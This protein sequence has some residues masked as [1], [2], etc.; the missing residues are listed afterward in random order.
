MLHPG[1]TG[2]GQAGFARS[3]SALRSPLITV[4]TSPRRLSRRTILASRASQDRIAR[5]VRPRQRSVAP[6]ERG[7]QPRDPALP[8]GPALLRVG[9]RSSHADPR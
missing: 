9:Q 6:G 1:G 8:A 3:P 2:V 5:M 7:D 4:V